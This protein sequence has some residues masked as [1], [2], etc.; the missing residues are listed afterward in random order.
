MSEE[1]RIVLVE[2][3]PTV[4]RYLASIIEE[5]PSMRVIGEARNGHEAVH[6]VAKLKPDVVSMDINM[7]Q[8]DGLEA[9]R[10]IMTQHPTPIVVVSGLLETD[11]QLSLQALEAGAL[12]VVG[13]PPDRHN[14]AFP[15]KQRE[16]ITTLRAMSGVRVIS[17]RVYPRVP[18]EVA[19]GVD[20][21]MTLQPPAQMTKPELLA[22][23]A[24]TGGPSA[25]QRFIK[26]LPADF[27]L[28][29]L[30]V[31]HMPH[32]FIPGLARWLDNATPLQVIVAQ[33]GLRITAGTIYI[34]PGSA[35]LIIR[36]HGAGLVTKLLKEPGSY[37]YTPSVDALFESVASLCGSA[38]IGL[39]LTGMGN[40]G[41]NGLLAMRRAGALTL[42][43]DEA[44]STVFGMPKA[45]V[46]IGAAQQMEPLLNLPSKILEML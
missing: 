11:V 18:Q 12:A 31:Q 35:H 4:R 7:P 25:I 2:D 34:A 3:S 16:L 24:S 19:P 45:A 43:Q 13:K 28:P 44:S 1:I 38:A 14:P 36:R 41:A 15:A 32:E 21:D 40:D 27:P 26:V 22:I 9:T 23:G 37:R 46:E 20:M 6:V 30:I 8:V 42:V 5:T 29:I 17:R 33:Q 39:V 10:R